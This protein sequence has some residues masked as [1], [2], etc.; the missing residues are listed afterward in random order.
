MKYLGPS[1]DIHTSGRELMFPHHENEIAIAAALNGKPLARFWVHCDRV[2]IDGKK[3]DEKKNRITLESLAAMGYSGRII[4]YWLLSGH[5][6]KP[7]TFSMDQLNEA[8]KSLNRLDSFI[9]NLDQVTGSKWQPDSYPE[10]DQVVYDIRSS[11]ITAMDDDLNISAALAS[12][13]T[14]IKQINRLIQQRVLDSESALK[15]L[16]AIRQVDGVLHVLR[17][18]PQTFPLDIQELIEKR[19]LARHQK[20]WELAD[21]IRDELVARRVVL[22][23]GKI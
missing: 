12:L 4:R 9:D 17:I 6:R 22:K 18:N 20:N 13:F 1:F 8:Q 19:N 23:D 15:I 3:V 14:L 16:A 2:L 10:I 11:F 21:Q 7:L 5:Y